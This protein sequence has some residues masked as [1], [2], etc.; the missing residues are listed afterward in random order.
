MSERIA[1]LYAAADRLRHDAA[2]IAPL[3]ACTGLSDAGVRLALERHLERD[4]DEARSGLAHSRF[5]RTNEATVILSANVFVAAFRA[6]LVAATSA[7]LVRVRASRREPVFAAA[8][9]R[10]AHELGADW[11]QLDADRELHTLRDVVHVYGRA[12]TVQA[13]QNGVPRDVTVYAHGPGFSAVWLSPDAA[14]EPAAVLVA[15]D[16]VPFD[17]RGCLSPRLT[18]VEE[19]GRA[20]TFAAALHAEL[21]RREASVPRGQLDEHE[22]AEWHRYAATWTMAGQAVH[23]TKRHLVVVAAAEA[24][25]AIAPIGRAMHVVAAPS[26]AYVGAALARV[27]SRLVALAS[28][29][30]ARLPPLQHVRL[31]R[32]GQLQRPP[33]DGP[34]DLRVVTS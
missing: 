25:P 12:E 34:V 18:F 27:S 9:I 4:V 26:A 3:R 30:P 29:A 32:L 8:L 10:A 1:L 11:L 28:D 33:M 17:Q 23:E 21:E 14:L 6:I 31:A 5:A 2:L 7:D 24:P 16:M 20:L 15:D 22:R 19:E 13:V